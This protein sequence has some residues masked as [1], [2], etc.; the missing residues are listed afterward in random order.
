MKCI[1][2]SNA[3]TIIME[4]YYMCSTFCYIEPTIGAETNRE[5]ERERE[6]CVRILFTSSWN[7]PNYVWY[8]TCAIFYIIH[9]TKA[10]Y[11]PFR[12]HEMCSS[13]SFDTL[14]MV[15]AI[16]FLMIE[17]TVPFPQIY[18]R[19]LFSQSSSPIAWICARIKFCEWLVRY[20]S[21]FHCFATNSMV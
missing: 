2:F 3:F 1:P 8:L 19:A 7:H 11:Q 17:N 9:W 13:F 12:A 18:C 14:W 4:I 5:K 10:M 15:F 20:F 16:R 21:C 6:I